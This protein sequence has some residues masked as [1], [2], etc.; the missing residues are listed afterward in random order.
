MQT[1]HPAC[2][3][4]VSRRSRFF[5]AGLGCEGN[6]T[7]DPIGG[8]PGYRQIFDGGDF[9]VRTA[10]ELLEALAQAR[11]G[12]V[13]FVPGGTEIDMAGQADVAL[14]PGVTLA[15]TRGRTNA[16]PSRIV[17]RRRQS[18]VFYLFETAGNR[19]RLTG[20]VLEGPDGIPSEHNGYTNLMR[21][22]H[23]GLEMDNCEVLNWGY[24]A[25]A[26]QPGASGIY[27][28]HCDI[29][30]AMGAAHDGYG[31]HLDGCDGRF[32]A[33]RFAAIHNHAIAGSGAPGTA[34]E[35]AYN[36]VDS[37]FDMHG[38]SDRGDG[39]DIGGDWMDIHHNTFLQI[40]ALPCITRGRPS[41]GGRVHHNR[42]AASVRES[43]G[44]SAEAALAERNIRAY[45]NFNGAKGI[46]EE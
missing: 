13:I 38:G 32:I 35:A 2:P 34:Y 44:R 16:P 7:G 31:I 45:R 19:V 25:I 12:Q 40:H 18:G 14:P 15:G 17:M 3:V 21:T 1:R 46:I 20:L 24:G 33:N 4:P 42:F 41:Q 29:H 9:T 11:S 23:H 43:I 28:H 30:D 36:L 5:P 10:A 6:P 37:N 26:G 8:G 22:R 39:T 27:V